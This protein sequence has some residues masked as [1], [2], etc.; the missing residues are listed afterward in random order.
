MSCKELKETFLWSPT[1]SMIIL[2][3][4]KGWLYCNA[5]PTNFVYAMSG[6]LINRYRIFRIMTN[7]LSS[8]RT[9][10]KAKILSPP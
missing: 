10:D 1:G 2:F 7:Y 5:L 3:L 8:S 4:P 9:N 6:R